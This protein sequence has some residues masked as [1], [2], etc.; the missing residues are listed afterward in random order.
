[1]DIN[2]PLTS[3]NHIFVQTVG[4]TKQVEEGIL[5]PLPKDSVLGGAD[6]LTNFV[7]GCHHINPVTV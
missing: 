4:M 3:F 5:S 6:D 1:M 2:Y 7:C